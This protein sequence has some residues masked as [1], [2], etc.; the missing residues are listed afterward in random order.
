MDIQA[1]AVRDDDD[2]Q[3]DK[4]LIFALDEVL[5]GIDMWYTREIVKMQPII[6]LPE[7]PDHIK[8]IINL[9]GIIIPVIDAR[10]RFAMEPLAYDD[11]TCIIVVEINNR[12]AGLIV[13]SV[14]DVLDIGEEDI[15][16][17]PSVQYGQ[18]GRFVKS[19]GQSEGNVVLLLD[20]EKLM[21]H[22]VYE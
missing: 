6:T 7:V 18:S 4:Y 10:C 11:R 12:L 15:S 3:K 22:R 19:I 1:L 14:S 9:R 17:A 13:D 20:A 5:Y 8:G 21:D 16:D 2:A